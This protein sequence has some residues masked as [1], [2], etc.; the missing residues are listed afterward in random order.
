LN[1]EPSIVLVKRESNGIW[2]N[3][4][5]FPLIETDRQLSFEKLRS[6]ESWQKMFN[7]QEIHLIRRTKVY[8]HVLSH[9]VILARFY[10]IKEIVRIPNR[11]IQVSLKD[12][13]SYP[14]PRLIEL[15]LIEQL[16][17]KP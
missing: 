3:L 14:V 17:L 6:T 5:D 12:L 7:G 16:I 11:S 9:Q 10:F 1:K 4:Y 15:F 2:K 13:H 8:R